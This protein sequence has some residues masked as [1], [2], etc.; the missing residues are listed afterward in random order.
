MIF[1]ALAIKLIQ[2]LHTYKECI[3]RKTEFICP[4]LHIVEEGSTLAEIGSVFNPV[5]E[6]S[7]NLGVEEFNR[8]AQCGKTA[9]FL[10]Q[11]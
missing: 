9:T 8:I 11:G 2:V 5:G 6:T 7:S 3:H 1:I 10:L 4:D